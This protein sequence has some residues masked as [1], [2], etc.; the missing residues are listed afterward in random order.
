MKA[1]KS[2]YMGEEF[3]DPNTV[4]YRELEVIAML[5]LPSTKSFG[6]V[7][8]V[9]RTSDGLQVL[10]FSDYRA[11]LTQQELEDCVQNGWARKVNPIV[12][13]AR[14]PEELALGW[15][16]REF[17]SSANNLAIPLP[18]LRTTQTKGGRYWIGESE[19]IYQEQLNWIWAAYDKAC[20]SGDIRR[21]YEAMLWVIPDASETFILERRLGIR[22]MAS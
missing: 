16:G 6:R 18:K 8:F 2:H 1:K 20:K 22:P 3:P 13:A 9:A 17:E 7:P 5:D 21:Y 12:I 10:G 11:R 14:D 4:A 19:R 15:I